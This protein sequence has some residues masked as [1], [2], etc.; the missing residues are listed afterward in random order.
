[1]K[2]L[3][4]IWTLLLVILAVWVG[5]RLTDNKTVQS[6]IFKII[7]EQP[8]PDNFKQPADNFLKQ[9][10]HTIA[11]L[12]KSDKRNNIIQASE[13]IHELIAD[14]NT[15]FDIPTSVKSSEQKYKALFKALY[16]YRYGLLAPTLKQKIQS[17]NA[18]QV[19]QQML[20][21][22]FSDSLSLGASKRFMHDPFGF[23]EGY[24]QSRRNPIVE[25]DDTLTSNSTSMQKMD[26]TI[27]FSDGLLYYSIFAIT[28]KQSVFDAQT[29]EDYFNFE[30]MIRHQ[31]DIKGI[32]AT[33]SS[34]GVL[35]HAA[36]SRQVAEQEIST[37]G[38]LSLIGIIT[39][40]LITLRSL[41]P[42]VGALLCLSGGLVT[43]MSLTVFAFGYLHVLTL[44]FGATVIGIA[45]DYAFHFYAHQY[46]E[47]SS[48]SKSFNAIKTAILLGLLTSIAGFSALL[49]TN[50]TALMQLATF[51]IGGLMGSFICV[52]LWLSQTA[53]PANQYVSGRIHHPLFFVVSHKVYPFYITLSVL[54]MA[55][56]FLLVKPLSGSDDI[57]LLRIHFPE[58]EQ[59]QKT[60]QAL[61]QSYQQ[62][63]FFLIAA[64]SANELLVQQQK[65]T[66]QLQQKIASN[67]LLSYSA[68]NDYLISQQELER[69]HKLIDHKLIH[70]K[71]AQ[72]LLASMGINHKVQQ[73]M[74]DEIQSTH[75]IDSYTAA[76]PDLINMLPDNQSY[77]DGNQWVGIITINSKHHFDGSKLTLPDQAIWYDKVASIN[78]LFKSFRQL[79]I[80]A[81]MIAYALV[82][83]IF[84]TRYGLKQGI[85]L[86]LPAISGIV[87]T[88]ALLSALNLSVNL[89]H[90]LATLIV[91][92]VGIDFSLFIKESKGDLKPALLATTLSACTTVLAFGLLAF[93]R[94][95]ALASFGQVIFAGIIIVY[96]LAPLTLT[97]DDKREA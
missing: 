65:I 83:I 92:A 22:N 72:S 27:I 42:I 96:L 31:L 91:L 59:T 37:I 11:L 82:L 16:P 26:D 25:S 64:K 57:K 38:S 41:K 46:L 80:K 33:L 81:L 34:T 71:H 95:P 77:F 88:L 79:A 21:T 69:N 3:S 6:D 60:I 18:E 15:V 23:F 93:S 76:L 13:L 36:K 14:F 17:N 10:E 43:A 86:L 39:L 44:V 19:L 12:I 52:S 56:V 30:S 63:G 75:A 61:T 66:Q 97:F 40:F 45:I 58:L 73:T 54:A 49:L 51:A 84:C 67:E 5:T 2:R 35:L 94:T 55:L 68:A 20:Q 89:F 28:M 4:F 1:M 47:R 48:G 87:L 7:P 24:I 70:T 32:D 29:Q 90:I 78:Q 62:S 50:F 8:I 85:A 9:Q 74:I 53:K